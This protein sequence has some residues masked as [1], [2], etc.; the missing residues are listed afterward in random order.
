MV[1]AT[2][3]RYKLGI[4]KERKMTIPR[5]S[6]R[7]KCQSQTLSYLGKKKKQRIRCPGIKQKVENKTSKD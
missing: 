7:R 3:F 1:F 6:T 4:E 2:E 5:A